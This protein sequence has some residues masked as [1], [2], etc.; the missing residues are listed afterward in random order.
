MALKDPSDKE[1]L[2][3]LRVEGGKGSARLDNRDAGATFGW[4]K[5]EAVA[6]FAVEMAALVDLQ[7][8]LF[9]DNSNSVL[10][11]LQAMDAAGKDSTIRSVFSGLNPAGVDVNPFGV[12][13]DEERVIAEQ[14]AA[15][16]G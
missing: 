16:V 12:P 8:R 6:L 15:L 3:Y 13:T 7:K 4:D 1:L 14:T 2:K 9:A 11:V 10:F 5:E